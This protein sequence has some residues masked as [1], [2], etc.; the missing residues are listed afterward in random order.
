MVVRLARARLGVHVG[1]G[2]V[3]VRVHHAAREDVVE[4][5]RD[6]RGEPM[7]RRRRDHGKLGPFF[8]LV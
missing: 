7:P 6:V 1:P 3:Q 5:Q 4:P 2:P 8:Q